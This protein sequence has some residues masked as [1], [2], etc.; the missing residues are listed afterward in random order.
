MRHPNTNEIKSK[1]I[2]PVED[3]SAWKKMPNPKAMRIA[4]AAVINL[5]RRTKP[6]FTTVRDSLFHPGPRTN[7]IQLFFPFE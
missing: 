1:T 7:P 5:P 6:V 2:Q 3:R 4:V